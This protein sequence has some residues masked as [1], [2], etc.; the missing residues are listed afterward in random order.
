MDRQVIVFRE[1]FVPRRPADI[2]I[3]AARSFAGEVAFPQ[4]I[5][6]TSLCCIGLR[7]GRPRRIH[8]SYADSSKI[9]ITSK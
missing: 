6:K 7:N 1:N 3:G 2:G 4:N 5:S 9:K 8:N